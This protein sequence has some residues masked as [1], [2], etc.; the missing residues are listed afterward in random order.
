VTF[1]FT[2]TI[3]AEVSYSGDKYIPNVRLGHVH[4]ENISCV[5]VEVLDHLPA[6]NVPE[7]RIMNRC[8]RAYNEKINLPYGAG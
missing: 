7:M 5:S 2:H 8:E 1:T 4:R 6:L 3:D